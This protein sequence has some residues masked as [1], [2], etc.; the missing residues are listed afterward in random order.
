[1][2]VNTPSDDSPDSILN[3]EKEISVKYSINLNN[4][5]NIEIRPVIEEGGKV[6]DSLTLF[7]HSS[8]DNRIGLVLDIPFM[9]MHE[10]LKKHNL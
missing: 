3:I 2:M 1:M 5:T 7:E 6:N 4:Y 10:L 9:Q 8:W